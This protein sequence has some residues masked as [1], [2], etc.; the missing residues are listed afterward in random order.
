MLKDGE[1]RRVRER[2]EHIGLKLP[3]PLHHHPPHRRAS[4][5]LNIA[6]C[7]YANLSIFTDSKSIH[8]AT[9]ILTSSPRADKLSMYTCNIEAGA[10]M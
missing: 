8:L 4:N 2:L 1:A 3:H 5:Q 7:E 9:E 6:I 10:A